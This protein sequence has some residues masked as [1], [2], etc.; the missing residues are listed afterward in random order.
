MMARGWMNFWLIQTFSWGFF[1]IPQKLRAYSTQ[2]YFQNCRAK[3]RLAAQYL[4]MADGANVRLKRDIVAALE[5]GVL[6]GV[7]LDVFEKEPLPAD[8]PTLEIHYAILTPHVASVS[9]TYAL[10]NHVAGQIKTV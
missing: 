6:G 7:S 3:H 10:A 9:D 8:S 1:H 2:S 5:S 4:S